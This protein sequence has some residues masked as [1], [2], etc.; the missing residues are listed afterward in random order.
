MAFD[1]ESS[2]G[3]RLRNWTSAKNYG[4][5]SSDFMTHRG[6]LE[7]EQ[8]AIGD[9]KRDESILNGM[10]FYLLLSNVIQCNNVELH[11]FVSDVLFHF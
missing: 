1:A 4:K 5:V 7:L 8:M 3:R 6:V 10:Q 2:S 9:P 11:I